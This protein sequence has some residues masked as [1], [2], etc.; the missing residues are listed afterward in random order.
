MGICII[1]TDKY[2]HVGNNTLRIMYVRLSLLD[3][4]KY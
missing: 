4:S 2:L 1:S 3:F